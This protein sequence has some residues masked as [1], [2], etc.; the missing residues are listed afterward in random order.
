MKRAVKPRRSR[1]PRGSLN[2]EQVVEAALRLADREGVEALTMPALASELECGVMTLYGYVQDKDDLLDAIAVRGLADLRL[3]PPLPV[4][5]V[6]VLTEWG[7][8]LRTALLAHPSMG[9]IFLNRVVIGPAIFTGLEALL[10]ALDRGGMPPSA[11]VHAVYAVLIY[12]AGFVAWEIPRTRLQPPS[13]YAA[14][15]RRE[16]A[17]LPASGFP[18]TET[19]LDELSLVAADQQ[20]ELGLA[21]LSAGLAQGTT[22]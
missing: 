1:R 19:V 22:A 16:F 14:A 6:A 17:A 2:R 8:A 5:P 15:W 12:T 7:R 3:E 20:F 21:A 18:L 13:A 11:G 4:H 10:R 9:L